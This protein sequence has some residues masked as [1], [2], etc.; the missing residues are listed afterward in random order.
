MKSI[1]SI[2]LD[3]TSHKVFELIARDPFQNKRLLDVGAGEGYFVQLMGQWLKQQNLVPLPERLFACDIQPGEFKYEEIP[4]H[5]ANFHEQ[6]PYPDQHFDIVTSIEVIEH[7]EDQFHFIREL[8]RVTKPGGQII[9]TTPN[10][11][12]INSRLRYF[13]T[14]F[15]LL[16]DILP[17]YRIEPTRLSGHIHPIGLYFLAHAMARAGLRNIEVHYDRKK[18]SGLFLSILLYPLIQFRFFLYRRR[19]A[20]KKKELFMENA[21]LLNQINTL[22]TLASRTVIMVGYR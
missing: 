16:F 5:S 4:C 18:K 13:F 22:D 15:G 2:S 11:L 8:Y 10:I 19:L 7:L 20:R 14:G 12:N 21:F 17:L 3:K 6:L 9:V 1:Q